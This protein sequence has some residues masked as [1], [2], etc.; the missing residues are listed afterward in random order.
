MLDS[1][2]KAML[3]M[4]LRRK[5]VYANEKVGCR[6]IHM[7]GPKSDVPRQGE[8]YYEQRI[9]EKGGGCRVGAL[10][11]VISANFHHNNSVVINDTA[12]HSQVVL[13]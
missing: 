13:G 9:S 3:N 1:L 12:K 5:F 2:Y 11:T 4:R 10:D 8:V 6:S 7:F